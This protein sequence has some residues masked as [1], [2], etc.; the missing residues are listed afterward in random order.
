MKIFV[1]SLSAILIISCQSFKSED[2]MNMSKIVESTILWKTEIDGIT[3]EPIE[4]STL[5][6]GFEF[7]EKAKSSNFY[8]VK[9]PFLVFGHEAVY[10]GLL[11]VGFIPGPNALV[12]GSPQSISNYISTS[13]GLNLTNNNGEFSTS[14][15]R[16]IKLVVASDP[17]NKNRSII[18]GAYLGP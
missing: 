9:K 4:L 10:I 8:K 14:L 3:W 5:V 13:Y 1:L 17:K 11:G 7:F 6:E 18:I 15:S 2:S 16:Y 12:K